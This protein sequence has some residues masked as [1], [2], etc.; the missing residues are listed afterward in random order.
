MAWDGLPVNR[1]HNLRWFEPNTCHYLPKRPV[2]WEFPVSRAVAFGAVMSHYIYVSPAVS[3]CAWTKSGQRPRSWAGPDGAFGRDRSGGK[4]SGAVH[5][6]ACF[7]NSMVCRSQRRGRPAGP[8]RSLVADRSGPR[9]DQLPMRSAGRALPGTDLSR[10]DVRPRSA[11]AG[12]GSASITGLWHRPITRPRA[13]LAQAPGLTSTSR[14]A[15]SLRWHHWVFAG[16]LGLAYRSPQA[17]SSLR[18]GPSSRPARVSTY[19]SRGGR[20]L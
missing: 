19:S 16:G 20:K 9:M 10:A 2:S 12:Q 13:R 5:R 15:E 11:A 6:T 14:G 3:S 18:T 1:R 4:R 17:R 7:W 8:G